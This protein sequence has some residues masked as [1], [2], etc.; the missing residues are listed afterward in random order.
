LTPLHRIEEGR[1]V[2][3]PV[4]LALLAL[5]ALPAAAAAAPERGQDIRKV[6]AITASAG[7][8]VRVTLRAPLD[9]RISVR[10]RQGTGRGR[11]RSSA[12]AHRGRQ[13]LFVFSG[14]ASNLASV[15]VSTRGDRASV[16]LPRRVDDC[17]ALARLARGLRPI[18]AGRPAIKRRLRAVAR[19]RAD[20]RRDAIPDLPAPPAGRGFASPVARYALAHGLTPEDPLEA[21]DAV[22]F[23]DASAGSELVDWRWDFGDGTGAAGP[24]ASHAYA[25]GR[26][27]ALLTVAN[28]RG[29]VSAFGRLLFVR[30]PGS[31]VVDV[32]PVA[33]P[34]PGRSVPVSVSVRVPAWAR[35]PAQ[36]AFAL[37]TGTCGATASPARD[38]AITPGNA[39][40]H[41]D[42]WG[43]KES[44][45]RFSFDLSDGSGTGTVTPSVTAGWS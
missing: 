13:V 25:P 22:R 23:A 12:V 10:F 39:G 34:G 4:L 5:L 11:P 19:H 43:R 38:L 41:R 31:T 37:P 3:R 15:L 33:C 2:A 32:D 8:L 21:G 29:G 45:L 1:E 6:E 42:A 18:R 44:T 20:C 17:A 24:I 27:T 30:G 16:K 26:Y 14:D 36:V 28:S 9:G 40:N 35:M 7:A